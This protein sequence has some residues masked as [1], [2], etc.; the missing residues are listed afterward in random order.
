M[1]A[2]RVILVEGLDLAGKSTLVRNL[3]AELTRRGVPVRVSRNALCPDNPIAALADQVRRDPQAGLIETGALFLA[4]HLWDARH[5]TPPPDGTVHLQDSCWLRTLAYHSWKDTPAIAE[6]LARAARYF[7]RF[8]FTV[9]LTAK[10]EERRHRLSQREREQPGSNDAN[11]HLVQSD[12]Q[13][14][15]RLGRMLWQMTHL[16]T[17]ATSVDTTGIPKEGLVSLVVE[18]LLEDRRGGE[19]P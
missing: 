17:K 16:Y 6:Q 13:G 1:M 10:S 15:S 14:H 4:A 11:D 3:Q 19:T 12:P 18:M 9:F 2:G 7:P 8:D 5:F